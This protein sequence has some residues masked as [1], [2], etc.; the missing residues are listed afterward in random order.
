MN[1]QDQVHQA[2]KSASPFD[3]KIIAVSEVVDVDSDGRPTIDFHVLD[4]KEWASPDVDKADLH[5]NKCGCCGQKIKYSAI[6][7]QISTNRI[8]AIGRICANKIENLKRY[9]SIIENASI[10]LSQKILC[11]HREQEFRKAHPEACE[12]LN[13]AKSGLSRLGA[14]LLEKLRRY[15]SLSEKQISLLV[16]VHQRDIAIRA[17]ATATA[18][19]G[20][21]S[22]E[23]TIL[24]VK[25]SQA[26]GKYGK[27]KFVV[28]V[29]I[30]GG[31]RV[32]GKSK[33]EWSH[34]AI[35]GATPIGDAPFQK[36]GDRVKFTATFEPSQKDPLFGFFKRPSKWEVIE[37]NAS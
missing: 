34:H 29:D 5:A 31:V 11:N 19:T 9:G 22:V 28:L 3:I 12:A 27:F 23:G 15:G 36:K 18:P 21:A 35:L 37:N 32:W 2:L 17:S 24:S 25:T 8:V 33:G 26:Q 13:W 16:D 4:E 1:S 30:G 14:D 10:A 20:R 6:V 7:K